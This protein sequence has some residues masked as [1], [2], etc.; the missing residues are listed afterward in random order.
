MILSRAGIDALLKSNCNCWEPDSPDDMWLGNC[1]R[2]LGIP[3]TH[4]PAFHQVCSVIPFAV[5]V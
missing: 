3:L 1:F 4:S 2:R 5:F